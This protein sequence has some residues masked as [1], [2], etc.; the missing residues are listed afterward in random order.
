MNNKYK[1][2]VIIS[3]FKADKYI[4]KFLSK[5]NDVDLNNI[6][7]KI[8][9]FVKSHENPLYINNEIK[10]STLIL[11]GK[12]QHI[13]IKD[14]DKNMDLYE[15]WNMG[16][17]EA[18]TPYVSNLNIDDYVDVNYFNKCVRF[19]D[20]NNNI[21]LVSSNYISYNDNAII[22][23]MKHFDTDNKFDI[24]KIN[25][26]IYYNTNK[27]EFTKRNIPHCCPVWRKEL[28]NKYGFFNGKDFDFVGD[29]E[30]WA[31]CLSKGEQF[32]N[33][34]EFLI[35][36]YTNNGTASDR[37]WYKHTKEY[38]N[39]SNIFPPKNY[40]E[41]HLGRE[42]DRIHYI[43]NRKII[44]MYKPK[45]SILIPLYNKENDILNTINSILK[46]NF[47]N[48]VILVNDDK[49]TDNSYNIVKKLVNIDNLFIFQNNENNERSYTRNKLISYVDTDY[50]MFLDADDKLVENSLSFIMNFK[51]NNNELAFGEFIKIKDG[52]RK[53]ISLRSTYTPNDFNYG[54][55]SHTCVLY[56]N[57][58]N[59]PQ[60]LTEYNGY[61]K[62]KCGEDWFWLYNM[63]KKN[64]L[65]LK[66]INH[67]IIEYNI[68]SSTSYSDREISILDTISR[69]YE[70]KLTK[71]ISIRI[72]EFIMLC[73]YRNINIEHT[74][75]EYDK[76]NNL[77]K[78]INNE[79][80]TVN[81]NA[82]L[83]VIKLYI[84]TV[85]KFNF[86]EKILVSYFY[87]IIN[88]YSYKNSFL[89]NKFTVEFKK[90]LRINSYDEIHIMGNGPS[91]KEY[92]FKILDKKNILTIGMNLA[93]RYWEQI[94]KYPDVYCC[95]DDVVLEHNRGDIYELI[96]KNKKI[97]LFYLRNIIYKYYP[98]L[99]S[100]NKVI[101]YEEI[102]NK[103]LGL[104]EKP[105]LTTGSDATKLGISL[106]P[107]KLF[108]FGIDC[109][110]IEIIDEAKKVKNGINDQ[111]ILV[112][113]KDIKENPNYF[114]NG[115][116]KKGDKYNIPDP[117]LNEHK[118]TIGGHLHLISFKQI[119]IQLKQIDLNIH[120]KNCSN[121][122]QIPYFEKIKY[123][124]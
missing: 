15:L 90:I 46:Q 105:L 82:V 112:I 120:I 124:F 47:K 1:L 94:N 45:L 4:K 26:L 8:Y 96:I 64:N 18:Y 114:F 30:F 48:Y 23:E 43:M 73:I 58:M 89:Y 20:M 34:N 109:N 49:S 28:H 59:I 3:C 70:L 53:H 5:L 36:N 42:H 33:I 116:Q 27:S 2:T 97:R 62:F 79:Q 80:L 67:P 84:T 66:N 11:S 123:N 71:N 95:L 115:Y 14:I 44:N 101:T 55:A 69:L 9:N 83:N 108:I 65:I 50:F 19:L 16:I 52:S 107:F 40:I 119:S 103:L 10:N 122:S 37:I 78:K 21:S 87:F 51:T 6:N 91:L 72:I 12:K 61:G 29:F 75:Y 100:N 98:E 111:D 81:I 56:K 99:K 86:D 63:L 13:L 88:K 85:K 77:Q 92:N 7:V 22:K 35:Y 113:D 121:I 41:T 17:K 102:G 106:M 104:F 68:N 93:Y 25:T 57:K 39:K 110:Y 117:L 31:R 76:S 60:F 74:L 54:W 24:Y 118:E 38:I 32:A